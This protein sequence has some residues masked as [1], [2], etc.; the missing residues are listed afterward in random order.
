MR[1]VCLVSLLVAPV[2]AMA[3]TTTCNRFGVTT[4]CET[5]GTTPTPGQQF[6]ENMNQANRDQDSRIASEAEASRDRR[7]RAYEQVGALIAKGD[8]TAANRLANFYGQRE[9][10]RDTERACPIR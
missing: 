4:T 1:F 3:Q 8:C 2:G 5:S 7:A 6:L 9:I 10:V